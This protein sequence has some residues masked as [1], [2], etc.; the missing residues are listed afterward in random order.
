MP[1]AQQEVTDQRGDG[2]DHNAHAGDQDQRGVKPAE[3][4]PVRRLKKGRGKPKAGT[5]T[6]DDEFGHNGADQG[7]AA[8]DPE[9]TQEVGQRRG[10]DR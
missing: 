5:G 10:A 4:E 9:A 8:R 2:E 7:Q 1:L 6:A 3:I